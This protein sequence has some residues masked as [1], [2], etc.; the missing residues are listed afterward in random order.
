MDKIH[1]I[2]PV[3]DGWKQTKTCLDALRASTYP[4]LEIIVVNH[5]SDE[6][7]KEA[8]PTQYPEI[9]IT[10]GEPS[11][12]WAGATNLGVRA[13]ISRGA[14]QIMLL[15]HD[16]YVEPDMIKIYGDLPK[17]LW[18]KQAGPNPKFTPRRFLE[19]ETSHYKGDHLTQVRQ[20]LL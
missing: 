15:N 6:E 1:I 10:R 7:I 5:G 4:S 3:F 14:K 20:F 17:E 2:I 11:L 13:A 16:C 19:A 18:D 8:L 9:L 12:W